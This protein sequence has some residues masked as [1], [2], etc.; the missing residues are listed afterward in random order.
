[1]DRDPAPPFQVCIQ[2]RAQGIS[3]IVIEKEEA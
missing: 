3:L 2:S 1:M